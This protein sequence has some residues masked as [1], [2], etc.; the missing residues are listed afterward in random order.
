M[1]HPDLC[2][3]CAREHHTV[4]DNHGVEIKTVCGILNEG[5]G[6]CRGA[7][8][9][10]KTPPY[11]I[12][13]DFLNETARHRIEKDIEDGVPGRCARCDLD[14][15]SCRRLLENCEELVMMKVGL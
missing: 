12:V 4:I 5:H 8:Y 7:F 11:I 2:Q 3:S 9:V 13:K 14:P 6:G 15:Y 1:I 10:L